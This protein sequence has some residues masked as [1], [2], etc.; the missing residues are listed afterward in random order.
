MLNYML[1]SSTGVWVGKISFALLMP[2]VRAKHLL[3]PTVVRIPRAKTELLLV[4]ERTHI[5]N[6]R[7]FSL[8]HGTDLTNQLDDFRSIAPHLGTVRILVSQDIYERASLIS[9]LG[10]DT[11]ISVPA[12]YDRSRLTKVRWS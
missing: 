3:A 11:K 10:P 4:W 1:V 9:L 7:G 12:I 5:A 6:H 2:I 8:H